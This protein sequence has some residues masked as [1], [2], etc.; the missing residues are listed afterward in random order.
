MKSTIL[1]GENSFGLNLVI[2]LIAG[3]IFQKENNFVWERR[4][5]LG[6]CKPS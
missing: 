6:T 2:T 1:G 5:R 3:E 4:E